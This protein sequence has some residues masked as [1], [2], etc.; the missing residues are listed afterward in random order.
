MRSTYIPDFKNQMELGANY[1]LEKGIMVSYVGW[2]REKRTYL[3]QVTI[4]QIA[5]QSPDLANLII[6]GN[7]DEMLTGL[8][9]QGFPDLSNKRAKKAI[10]AMAT[11]V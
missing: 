9:Q 8:I 10:R 5:Q 11:S 3:Q 7:D 6:D 4:D 2:K 1:L